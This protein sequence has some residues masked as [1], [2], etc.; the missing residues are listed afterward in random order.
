M[1]ENK[2]GGD[3][4]KSVFDVFHD[5]KEGPYLF[6]CMQRPDDREARLRYQKYLEAVA[7]PRSEPLRLWLEL[8]TQNATHGKSPT[9]VAAIRAKLQSLVPR[10]DRAWWST[11]ARP[12]ETFNCGQAKPE[13]SPHVRFRF[14]CPQSWDLLTET[15]DPSRR[16]C[17]VCR[18]TVHFADS[19]GKAESLARQGKCIAVPSA[20]VD[21]TAREVTEMMVGRPDWRKMWAERIFGPS[22][23]D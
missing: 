15:G 1:R 3:M 11:V 20:I 19:V 18:E 14:E 9:E 2:R 5:S 8:P 21:K 7:D 13:R 10:L 23:D 12:L 22:E 16:H 4:K 6:A 17:E